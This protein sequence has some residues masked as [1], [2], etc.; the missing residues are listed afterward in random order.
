MKRISPARIGIDRYHLGRYEKKKGK[1]I[2]IYITNRARLKSVLVRDLER[3]G[4]IEKGAWPRLVD[5]RETFL[6]T[7][8]AAAARGLHY[9]GRARLIF[10]VAPL[11]RS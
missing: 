11:K 2:Y 4:I 10:M 3:C 7:L 8:E 5:T 1:Y 6:P 9:P